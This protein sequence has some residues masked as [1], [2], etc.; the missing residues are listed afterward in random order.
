MERFPRK[1]DMHMHTTASD[2]TDGPGELLEKIRSEGIGLFAVSDH[3]AVST[4][5]ALAPLL[6]P[7]DP[8]SSTAWSSPAGTSWGAT[9][10]WVTPT[11]WRTA[12]W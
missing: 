5:A 1:I 11:A 6:G 4:C 9:T 8:C 7:G 3:D 12:R 2:G 10:S